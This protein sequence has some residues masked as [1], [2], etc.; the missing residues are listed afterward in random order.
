[1]VR[2][3]SGDLQPA[4]HSYFLFHC[5]PPNLEACR[6]L[7]VSDIDGDGDEVDECSPLV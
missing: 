1:M 2:L 4:R 5:L 6:Y 7:E 3:F